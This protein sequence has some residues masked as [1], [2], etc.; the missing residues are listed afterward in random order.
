MELRQI[1]YFCQV[2]K[3]QNVTKAAEQLRVAQ[4]SVTAS[5]K[6]LEAELGFQLFDRSRRQMILTDEGRVFF[7]RGEEILE[8]V[9]DTLK[10]ME[11]LKTYQGG[12][13][14]IGIPPMIGT[15]LFPHVFVNF[16]KSY[17]HIELNIWEY[18][19]LDTRKMIMEGQLDMGIV[20]ITGSSDQ[21]ETLPVSQSQI[22]ACLYPGHP[23]CDQK[24]LS[25]ESLKDED[26]IMLKEGFYHRKEMMKLFKEK[27]YRPHIVLAS[28]QLETIKSL[29]R[30]K[31][32]ISFLMKDVIGA[33]EGIIAVSLLENVEL[34]IGLAWRKD[35]YLS[36]AAKTFIKF[37]AQNK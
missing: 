12:S 26:L 36:K 17:P 5:I 32:G 34:Q 8:K 9:E 3:L 30:S 35:R 16:S 6:K 2:A 4:P 22:M 15:Y 1:Q 18:G 10:E 27:G 37:L 20:I 33:E 19:S 13:L 14:R 21:L 25:I 29:V 23:L 24:E 7:M 31:V 28:S 11:D